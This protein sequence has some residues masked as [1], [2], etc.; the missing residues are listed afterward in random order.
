MGLCAKIQDW[1]PL[2]Q[3]CVPGCGTGTSLVGSVCQGMGL[4]PS[5]MGLCAK[6]WD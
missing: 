3:V 5:W 6:A 1:N 4:E 2:E